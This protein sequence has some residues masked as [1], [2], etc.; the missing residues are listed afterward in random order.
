MDVEAVK[1]GA[2]GPLASNDARGATGALEQQLADRFAEI[3][4]LTRMLAEAEQSQ[5]VADGRFEWLLQ[6]API[7][8]RHMRGRSFLGVRV[9][10][11]SKF[12]AE[13]KAADLFDPAAYLKANADVRE[14]GADALLHYLTHGLHEKRSLGF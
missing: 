5:V 9:A 12:L 6:V 7:M 4:T 3:A 2:G 10:D 14:A 1:K 13:L 11:D 8:R